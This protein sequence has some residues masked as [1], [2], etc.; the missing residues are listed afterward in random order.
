M[1]TL[2]RRMPGEKTRGSEIEPG[3][4]FCSRLNQSRWCLE[5]KDERGSDRE[6]GGRGQGEPSLH[7]K[8]ATAAPRIPSSPSSLQS[9]EGT[10]FHFRLHYQS[11][12]TLPKHFLAAASPPTPAFPFISLTRMVHVTRPKPITGL[13]GTITMMGSS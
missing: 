3:K 9:Q 7:F 6:V 2:I 10:N 1:K 8:M 5:K 13:G 12:K 4:I 11:Q